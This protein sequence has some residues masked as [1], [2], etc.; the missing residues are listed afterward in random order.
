MVIGGGEI[1]A[2]ALPHASHTYLTRVDTT[3]A[4]ADAYF[5]VLDPT[6]WIETAR[7][8]HAADATHAHAFTF[9]DYT[10]AALVS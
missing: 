8:D 3:T 5:P 4:G 9:M 2:L 10:R 7:A 1:Y 6:E